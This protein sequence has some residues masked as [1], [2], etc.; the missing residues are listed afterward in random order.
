MIPY[1]PP[2][3][4]PTGPFR[5]Q[6]FSVLLI[7]GILVARWMFLR[8]AGRAG[9][10]RG[11]LHVLFVWMLAAGFV[12]VYVPALVV[13]GARGIWSFGGFVGA[14]L[15]SIVWFW[16]EKFGLRDSLRAIDALAFAAPFACAAGRLGC[17]LAHD[18][19][20]LW[21]HSWIAVRFPEGPRYDLG[22]LEFLCLLGM[23][24]LFLVL[25]RRRWP[26][27]FWAGLFAV[28][29]S[30]VRLLLNDLQ[31]EPE[32]FHGWVPGI[33]FGVCA[34]AAMAW[35]LRRRPDR[36]VLVGRDGMEFSS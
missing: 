1:L 28:L 6:L 9:F 11:Q 22:F 21:T 30:S 31:F 35:L 29:Y 8:R 24:C 7:A 20:G 26:A 14:M 17:A 15:A 23:A 25:D 32:R 33:A 10:D 2:P 34:W 27:G 16:R 3:V 19:R 13:S 4:L 12:G 36:G 5:I 18:H